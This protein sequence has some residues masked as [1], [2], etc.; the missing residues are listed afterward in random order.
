[1]TCQIK[2]G[3]IIVF[4]TGGSTWTVI[5]LTRHSEFLQHMHKNTSVWTHLVCHMYV[6]C[7][8]LGASMCFVST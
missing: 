6:T 8:K 1:M 3:F 7:G 5:K 4:L 2:E